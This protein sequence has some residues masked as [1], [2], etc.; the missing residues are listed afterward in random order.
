MQSA[1]DTKMTV[2]KS[3]SED[4]ARTQ[5]LYSTQLGKSVFKFTGSKYI[6]H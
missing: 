5:G 2:G 6:G 1:A 3:A 4:T